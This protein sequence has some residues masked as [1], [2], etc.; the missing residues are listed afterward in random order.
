MI[1]ILKMPF[2]VCN[3]ECLYV[4]FYLDITLLTYERGEGG[5]CKF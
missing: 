2:D 5:L 4:E 1:T 3:K